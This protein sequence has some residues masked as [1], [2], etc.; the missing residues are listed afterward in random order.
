MSEESLETKIEFKATGTS[1]SIVLYDVFTKEKITHISELVQKRI[2]EYELVYSR[3]KDNSLVSRIAQEAGVFV[4]PEDS[5]RLFDLYRLV[6]D[7]TR[8]LVTPLIGQVIVDAGYDSSYSLVPKSEIQKAKKWDD[9]MTFEFPTLTTKEPVQLD[10]GAIGKGYAIDIVGELLL[11][12]GVTRFVIDAGGDIMHRN[13]SQILRVG[14][15]NPID[16]SEVLGVVNLGDT[17]LC[18]SSGNRRVWAGFNHIIDPE[19]VESPK[20]ISALW[21]V[22]PST[23][24]ADALSTALFFT[25]P[26]TLKEKF[27]F[28]FVIVYANGSARISSGFPGS[29]FA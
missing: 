6:Y 1:W 11:A 7:S 5:K 22:A 2:A 8:G 29:L 16:F 14:L 20:H 17:S 28:E 27:S 24:L 9:V 26:E 3:F 15:E 21:V 19:K 23:R 4:F 12:E 18:G 10:F 25:E 13:Q